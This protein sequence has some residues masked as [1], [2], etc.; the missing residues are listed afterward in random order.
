MNGIDRVDKN[1]AL[2]IE[3][4]G[5]EKSFGAVRV[6]DGVDLAVPAGIVFALLG[7]KEIGRAHV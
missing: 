6:L 2:A 5:L 4:I 1:G 7:P 3:A